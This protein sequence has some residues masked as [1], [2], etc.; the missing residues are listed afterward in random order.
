MSLWEYGYK[1]CPSS[2]SNRDERQNFRGTTQ[3]RGHVRALVF[4]LTE[5]DPSAHFLA[6]A[7]ERTPHHGTGRL[8]AGDRPS[9]GAVFP[10]WN[11]SL[12]AFISDYLL[13]IT[14]PLQRC[15][16]EFW[17]KSH[18]KRKIFHFV[19]DFMRETRKRKRRG[20]I[21]CFT[22]IGKADPC[23]KEIICS[24]RRRFRRQSRERCPGLLHALPDEVREAL[25]R[26][27]LGHAT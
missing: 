9:L 6:A 5:V 14:H 11:L 25:G 13:F 2:Q 12:M 21:T 20:R 10:L 24:A 18:K 19:F 27:R 17:Q 23:E 26:R 22:G 7:P 1:K 16:G 3:L 8:S 15:K 4:P